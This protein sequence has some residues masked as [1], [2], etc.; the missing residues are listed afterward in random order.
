MTEGGDAAWHCVHYVVT[1]GWEV[2]EGSQKISTPNLARSGAGV[3]DAG[4]TSVQIWP[5]YLFSRRL[6]LVSDSDR[7]PT[8]RTPTR[9]PPGGRLTEDAAIRISAGGDDGGGGGGGVSG[10]FRLDGPSILA[11]TRALQSTCRSA[12][13]FGQK[14][15]LCSYSVH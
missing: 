9:H 2:R 1:C 7:H 11:R 15:A 10:V 3:G 4:P 14:L 13:E 8:A 12:I 5:L 6:H